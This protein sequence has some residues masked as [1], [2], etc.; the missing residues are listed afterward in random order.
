[1]AAY[2]FHPVWG[3]SFF[4]SIGNCSLCSG[5][6]QEF[7]QKILARAQAK[8]VPFFKQFLDNIYY[9]FLC[10]NARAGLLYE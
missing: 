1:M 10:E 7:S 9:I 2:G 5:R 3:G 8:S 6:Q 4:Y